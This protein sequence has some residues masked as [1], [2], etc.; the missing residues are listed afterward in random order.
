[1]SEPLRAAGEAS[2][3][4]RLAGRRGGARPAA[5]AARRR[6]STSSSPA[7]RAAWRKRWPAPRRA[8]AFALSDEF[9]AWRVVARERRLAGRSAAADGRD[10]RGR[11]RRAATSPSTRSPSRSAAASSST[12]SAAAP[13][14]APGACGWC[15]ATPSPTIRCACCGC[16]RLACELGFDVEPET[17]AAARA[18]A[19]GACP[20]GARARVRGAQA[21][22][23]PPRPRWPG[24]T[25]WT[26]PGRPPWCCPS[27]SA[28]RGVEQSHYHHL[29]VHDHTLSVLAETIALERDPERGLRPGHGAA[30]VCAARRAARQRADP[31]TGAALRRAAARRRQA[32]DARGDGRWSDH[33][34]GPRRGGRRD[35]P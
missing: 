11:P 6:T 23:R 30:L 22:R 14:S 16:A 2:R 17:L 26:R 12:R 27:S 18:A 5:R 33:V 15:P 8:T 32:A 3:D 25:C 7:T 1:M 19:P 10:D 4:R 29:D 20:G 35:V 34:H 9:G 21:D 24:S 13:T 31:R 28:L